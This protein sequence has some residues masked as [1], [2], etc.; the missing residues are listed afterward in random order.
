[1]TALSHEHAGH[2]V[3]VPGDSRIVFL[4]E[5]AAEGP[6]CRI[7]SNSVDEY[8]QPTMRED[9]LEVDSIESVRKGRGVQG[10]FSFEV[11]KK[12]A[13]TRDSNN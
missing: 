7:D 9:V 6:H 8:G 1:M 12:R 13:S 2:D 11:T 10:G 3:K 4:D 5:E